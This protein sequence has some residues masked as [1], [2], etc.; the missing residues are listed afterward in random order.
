[1]AAVV[2]A[3]QAEEAMVEEANYTE[4][5]QW[6][7]DYINTHC[8]ERRDIAHAIPGKQPGTKYTWMFY[9]RR[10]LYNPEFLRAVVT[11]F[12]QRVQQEIGHCNFQLSGM[13]SAA[14]PL[15]IGISLQT[16]IP[17][18][19]V[20]KNRKTYG[21]L[22]WIEGVPRVDRPVLL[23][24]DLCNSSTS[25]RHAHDRCLEHGLSILPYSFVLVNKVNKAVHE[26]TRQR[27]DMY[28]PAAIKVIYLWDLDDFNL[29]NPSH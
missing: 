20:R 9:L 6:G 23:V 5:W 26:K 2:V 19:S 28:L 21:L 8:I 27:R 13:E 4:L 7:K 25:L 16:N 1:M 22:N 24:D 17:A 3:M 12:T 18:F 29:S 11:M 15:L 10:A 14:V